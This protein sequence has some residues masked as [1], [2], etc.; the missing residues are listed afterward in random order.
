MSFVTVQVCDSDGLPVYN[1]DNSIEFDV[2]GNGKLIATDNGDSTCFIPFNS[3]KRDAFGGLCLGIIKGKKA[4][5]VEIYL[6]VSGDG[7]QSDTLTLFI[8]IVILYS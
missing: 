6:K 2:S 1:A 4:H 3:P 8:K 5:S 7:L